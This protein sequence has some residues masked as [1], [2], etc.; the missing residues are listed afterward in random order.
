VC[1]NRDIS[2]ILHDLRFSSRKGREKRWDQGYLPE[3][4]LSGKNYYWVML[5]HLVMII[6]DDSSLNF[7]YE[8]SPM[9]DVGCPVPINLRY[10]ACLNHG[11]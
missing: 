4:L 1:E 3:K 11:A 10:Y 7:L 9:P 5:F 8:N 6:P 2:D